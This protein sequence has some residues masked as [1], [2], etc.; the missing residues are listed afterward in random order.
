MVAPSQ[1]AAA[2]QAMT[3]VELIATFSTLGLFGFLFSWLT[4]IGKSYLTFY[5]N[6]VSSPLCAYDGVVFS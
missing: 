3:L 4:D 6:A 5:C 2:I 1:K